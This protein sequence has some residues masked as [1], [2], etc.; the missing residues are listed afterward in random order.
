MPSLVANS[1]GQLISDVS[2]QPEGFEGP[3]CR[4]PAHPSVGLNAELIDKVSGNLIEVT[5]EPD[6]TILACS[7]RSRA[8]DGPRRPDWVKNGK[9]RREHSTSAQDPNVLQNSSPSSERAIIESD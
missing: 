2:R 9:A 6:C 4:P 5:P 8:V 7:T 1:W 3:I